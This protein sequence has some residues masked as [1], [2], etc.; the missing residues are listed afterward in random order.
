MNGCWSRLAPSLT[1]LAG[2]ALGS[3]CGEP[4][5][6][7]LPE[8]EARPVPPATSVD[9]ALVFERDQQYATTANADFPV[10]KA[11]QSISAWVKPARQDADEVFFTMRRG[12]ESGTMFGFSQGRLT[13]WSVW[14]TRIFVQ[15]AASI[16]SDRWYHVAHV[17]TLIDDAAD[18]YEQRLYLD[19][20]LVAEG[21]Q[22]PQSRT[23]TSS[24][25]GSFD[26][27]SLQYQGCLDDL[28]LYARMLSQSEVQAEAAGERVSAEG[29]VA[30]W[31]F[32]ET[33]GTSIVYDRSGNGNH[34]TLGDGVEAFMPDRVPSEAAR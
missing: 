1:L 12:V 26:G 15:A 30:F 14:G 5:G 29:L 20:E 9:Y 28:R 11:S 6:T 27:T 31:P 17:Q 3:A 4:Q 32:D 8:L 10:A 22:P 7:T 2:G 18:I 24:W 33:P 23:P 34:G 19:G 13:A 21:A 25:L 16:V